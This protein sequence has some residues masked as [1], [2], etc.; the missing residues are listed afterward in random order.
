MLKHVWRKDEKGLYLPKDKPEIV[1]I[2][3][4]NFF[5]LEGKGNPNNE[6]FSDAIGVLYSLSYAVKMGLKNIE[7]YFD[8][9]VY[10]L[11]GVWDLAEEARSLNYLDKDQLIYTIMI[12]QPEFVTEEIANEVINNVKIKKSHPLLERLIFSS[13]EEGK[14][15][16]ML[17]NGSYDEEPKSFSIMEEFCIQNN[18]K[19]ISKVHKEIYISDARKTDPSKLKTVLRFKIEDNNK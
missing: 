18:L 14:C 11:E 19:R 9:T 13:L 1:S 16:Q 10:P 8:Y 2:P 17:H 3:K 5:M 12:R 15:I 4:F 6:A 7:N